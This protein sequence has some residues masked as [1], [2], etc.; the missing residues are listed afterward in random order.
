MGLAKHHK[1]HTLPIMHFYWNFHQKLPV[2]Q[3]VHTQAFLLY[4]CNVHT[5]GRP[6][7]GNDITMTSSDFQEQQDIIVILIWIQAH[8]NF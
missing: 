1:D 4:I 8:F 7:K 5:T 3:C 2:T 6:A